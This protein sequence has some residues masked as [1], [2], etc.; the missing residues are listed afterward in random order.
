MHNCRIW[1]KPHSSFFFPLYIYC[2]TSVRCQPKFYPYVLP[3]LSKGGQFKIHIWP[4]GILRIQGLGRTKNPHVIFSF[5]MVTKWVLTLFQAP[6]F[7][8]LIFVLTLFKLLVWCF[9]CFVFELQLLM[10]SSCCFCSRRLGCT[11]VIFL[12]TRIENLCAYP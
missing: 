2:D 6:W 8:S 11:L 4:F 1:I 7:F 3:Y 9:L 5:F 10:S 12:K